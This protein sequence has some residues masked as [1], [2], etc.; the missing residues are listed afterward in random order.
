MGWIAWGWV[1]ESRTQ[2]PDFKF[3]IVPL[4]RTVITN[5]PPESS[6]LR[7]CKMCIVRE[8]RPQTISASPSSCFAFRNLIPS[9][10]YGCGYS[11][12]RTASIARL[13]YYFK[14]LILI[15]E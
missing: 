15:S 13:L 8:L 14:V 12:L 11:S 9:A 1:Y 4:T 7:L 2:R 6:E 10:S 5:A 3:V